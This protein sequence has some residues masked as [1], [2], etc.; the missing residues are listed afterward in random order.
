M[1][2]PSSTSVGAT[3]LDR[4]ARVAELRDAAARS[5]T[6]LPAI[7]KIVLFGSLVSGIP[8]PRSD[9]DLL[10]EVSASAHALARDRVPEVLE[11]LRPLPCPVD[12]FVYTTD[13]LART[14]RDSPVVREALTHG[15]VLWPLADEAAARIDPLQPPRR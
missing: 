10:I 14:Y 6:R 15:M 4:E 12:L 5:A 2:R 8:T 3:Y 7:Q 1:H 13:E 9:A 11:A